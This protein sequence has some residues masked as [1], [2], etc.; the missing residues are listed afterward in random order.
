MV[1]NMAGALMSV[2]LGEAAP[3]WIREV[4]EMRDRTRAGVTAPAQ[5]LCLVKVEY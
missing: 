3:L 2:G 5:G 1:R 4:I